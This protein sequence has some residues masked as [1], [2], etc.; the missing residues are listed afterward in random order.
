MIKR[1]SAATLDIPLFREARIEQLQQS[2][3]SSIFAILNDE[4]LQTL[5][6]DAIS[7]D[8]IILR[9]QEI[10]QSVFESDAEKAIEELRISEQLLLEDYQ[11]C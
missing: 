4:L 10:V 11:D 7:E 9:V 5:K 1:Q 3:S 6:G 8:Y 2:M